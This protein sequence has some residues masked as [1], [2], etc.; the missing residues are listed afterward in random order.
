MPGP[1]GLRLRA[2]DLRLRSEPRPWF[3]PGSADPARTF[4]ATDAPGKTKFPAG[5]NGD[6]NCD[7]PFTLEQSMYKAIKDMF[8]KAAFSLFTGDIIDHGLFNTSKEYNENSSE[9]SSPSPRAN[10]R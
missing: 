1:C 10:Q 7:V 6:H 8:P 4:N 5:P 9:S 3:G 2:P